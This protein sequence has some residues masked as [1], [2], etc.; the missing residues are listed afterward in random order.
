MLVGR[1]RVTGLGGLVRSHTTE[2]IS[3]MAIGQAMALTSIPIRVAP[4]EPCRKFDES[5]KTLRAV[6]VASRI[7]GALLRPGRMANPPTMRPRSSE[8][9][10]GRAR[11]TTA[12]VPLSEEDPCRMRAAQMAA[13]PSPAMAPSSQLAEVTRLVCWRMKKTT[14]TRASG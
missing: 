13:T 3:T 9:P 4:N 5:P 6:P 12:A 7:Q 8:S 2:A 14:A 10:M 11:L 1:S